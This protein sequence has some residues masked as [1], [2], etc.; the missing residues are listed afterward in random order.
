MSLKPIAMNHVL[1]TAREL[2]RLARRKSGLTGYVYR[3]NE[4]QD[5]QNLCSAL[6]DM[7]EELLRV[8]PGPARP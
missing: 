6:I 1:E 2:N 5:V 4:E 7:R 8:L 3:E